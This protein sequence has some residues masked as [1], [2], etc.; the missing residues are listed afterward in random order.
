LKN[1]EAKRNSLILDED[2]EVEATVPD[3]NASLKVEKISVL[4]N[5]V[6]P[7]STRNDKRQSQR[8]GCWGSSFSFKT[9]DDDL[10]SEIYPVHRSLNS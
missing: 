9:K 2:D 7:Q 8:S 10:N 4:S 6:G 1:D 3:E 5:C